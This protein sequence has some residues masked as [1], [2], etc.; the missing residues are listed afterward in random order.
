MKTYLI[1]P[2]K[3]CGRGR[4]VLY[5]G[6]SEVFILDR[7]N[8]AKRRGLRPVLVRARSLPEA[9]RKASALL[10]GTRFSHY[11]IKLEVLG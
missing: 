7:P 5:K 1:K 11:D 10:E 9:N 8:R 6:T 4:F 3:I 2:K